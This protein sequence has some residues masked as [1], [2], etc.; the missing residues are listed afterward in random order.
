MVADP[1]GDRLPAS[2][3]INPI[4]P[5]KLSVD[6]AEFGAGPADGAEFM[7]DTAV[8]NNCAVHVNAFSNTAREADPF[9]SRS[10]AAHLVPFSVVAPHHPVGKLVDVSYPKAG[11]A[12][13][14]AA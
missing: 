9:H 7:L 8:C 4:C 3:A 2:G 5:G 12:R 6:R 10:K 13:P 14:K 11:M 1:I